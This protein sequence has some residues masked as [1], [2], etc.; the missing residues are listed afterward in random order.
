MTVHI[1]I[2]LNLNESD[3]KKLR[4]CVN[5]RDVDYSVDNDTVSIFCN[6][7]MGIHQLTL[8][9]ADGAKVSINDVLID[10]ASVRHTLYMSYIKTSTGKI[11]QPATVVHDQLQT[12]VL[13]FG[14][15][16]SRW[17]ELTSSKIQPFDFGKKLYEIYDIIY[18]DSIELT[19]LQPKVIQDFFKHNF[20][21]YC[22]PKTDINFLPQRKCNIDISTYN[23]QEVLDEIADNILWIQEHQRPNSENHYNERGWHGWDNGN[24]PWI[25]FKIYD[26]CKCVLPTERLPK[27]Q[28]LIKKLPVN[29]VILSAGLGI[30]APGTAIHPHTDKK[31]NH[32]PGMHGCNV[33]YIPLLWPLGNYFKI[34]SAGSID[35]DSPWFIN[36]TDYV[37]AAVNDSNQT[38]I[39]LNITL[40]P[41][42]NYHLLA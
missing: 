6:I 39:I 18:P 36:V 42:Q 8:Q 29:G 21:F 19:T 16:V 26:G 22:R 25:I 2:K 4:V 9:L 17:L 27:L 14:Y 28:S 33:L 11:N 1:E 41:A 37:H 20:D 13:P 34:A 23:V 31:S 38:R 7:D 10:T 35:S 15:P 3:F 32:V 5:R 12:W 30:L 24:S 40:D